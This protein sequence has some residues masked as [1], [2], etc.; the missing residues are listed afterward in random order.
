M[1]G[2]FKRRHEHEQGGRSGFRFVIDATD[3]LRQYL[4]LF[5][6]AV[7]V[8]RFGRFL[9]ADAIDNRF[10]GIGASH[11]SSQPRIVS[12]HSVTN[13]RAALRID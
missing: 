8:V 11:E 7:I 12:L 3:H 6:I 5:L 13:D 2:I 9:E 10:A 4:N 1:R